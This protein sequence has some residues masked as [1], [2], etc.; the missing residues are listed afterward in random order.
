MDVLAVSG[1]QA[2]VAMVDVPSRVVRHRAGRSS[3]IPGLLDGRL[4][5]ASALTQRVL[6]LDPDLER[7]HVFGADGERIA[8]GERSRGYPVLYDGGLWFA[9]VDDGDVLLVAGAAGSAAPVQD[10]RIAGAVPTRLDRIR[11]SAGGDK[12]CFVSWYDHDGIRHAVLSGKKLRRP[13]YVPLSER[14]L[15]LSPDGKR[16]LAMTR[17]ELYEYDLRRRKLRLLHRED[18]C[19]VGHAVWSV[20]GASIYYLLECDDQ[21]TEIRTQPAK[22]NAKPR[23]VATLDRAL[24][25]T[26]LE[27]LGDDDVV[28]S[29]TSYDSRL[30]LID[31]LPLP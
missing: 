1:S 19:E 7:V 22:P 13:F 27:V 29:T 15:D 25:I 16:V 9:H 3:P 18:S 17:N 8:D 24:H 12:Q 10:L 26:G 30:V 2:L 5:G 11:C 21:P 28:Y 4:M 20:D 31:G 23:T 6:V 14:D